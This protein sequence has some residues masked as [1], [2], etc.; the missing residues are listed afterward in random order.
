MQLVNK[1]QVIRKIH[2]VKM[3]TEYTVSD[4]LSLSLPCICSSDPWQQSTALYLLL[5][6]Y[7][8]ARL[9][10]CQHTV[11]QEQN[12]TAD[13]KVKILTFLLATYVHNPALGTFVPL[14]NTPAQLP[15]QLL[16][17]AQA[18]QAIDQGKPKLKKLCLFGSLYVGSVIHL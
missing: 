6:C 1:R 2:Q 18:L 14:P 16:S 3:C 10:L 7:L 5:R 12:A 4:T 15:A 8:I 17:A 13:T 11:L 9:I